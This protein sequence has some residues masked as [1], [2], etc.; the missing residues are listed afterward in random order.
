MVS[1]KR[2][3]RQLAH[4]KW[5]RQQTRR[6][7]I[8]RRRRTTAWIVGAAVGVVA[9][10]AAGWLVISLA[11]DETG[12]NG[13]VPTIPIDTLTTPGVSLPSTLQTLLTQTTPATGSPSGTA[14]TSAGSGQRTSTAPTGSPETG[15]KAT[16]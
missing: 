6:V 1:K 12:R 14:A 11:A 8:Q 2:R 15:T 7:R 13:Q 16:R 4:A 5:E 3:R 10:V 9:V